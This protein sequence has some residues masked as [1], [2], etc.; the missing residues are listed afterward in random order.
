MAAFTA[1]NGGSP[2]KTS[3][4]SNPSIP[5][6][7][8]MRNPSDERSNGQPPHP[9]SKTNAE[10][11]ANQRE[12]W[13]G[14]NQDRSPYQSANY[15]D[16]DGSLKR[17]RSL[18]P[19][20]EHAPTRERTPDQ[21]SQPR[22][23][24]SRE[25]YRSPPRE[26][27]QYADRDDRDGDSWYSREDRE[28][29]AYYE[30]TAQG[31]TEEQIGEALRRANQM[32]SQGDYDNNSPDGDDR[33]MPYSPYT[34][35]GG[36][37]DPSLHSDPK[38]R[39]RN[40][41]NRTK[42]GCMTCRRRK[43]KCD[44]QKPECSNCI[45]GGFVCA[46][47]PPQ[48]N[49]A[50]QKPDNKVAAIPL[51]SKDPS[52]VPP[53][54]YGMPQQT[55]YGNQP[56]VGQP[57]QAQPPPQPQ[58]QQQQQQQP[59]PPPPPQQQVPPPPPPPPPPQPQ[60][61]REPLPPYRGQ[62]LRIDTPQGRPIL[63]EDDRP[64]ATALSAT[65]MSAL[66]GSTLTP[67]TIPS[68]TSA[69]PDKLAAYAG[70]FSQPITQPHQP[71]GE[72]KEYQRIPPLH[73]VSRTA[74]DPDTPHPAP[75]LP[76]ITIHHPTRSNSPSSQPPVTSN[77]QVAAQLALSHTFA[78]SRPRSQKE[79][80]LSGRHYYPFDK[81]LVLER[82][83]CS[84]A[85]W[86]FNNSTNPN[87][88]VS[89]NER[90]RLFREILQPRDASQISPTNNSPGTPYGRVGE[91]VVVEAPFVCDYGYNIS[92]GQNVIVGRN[93]TVIDTC[94]VKIGDNCHIGPNVSLYTATLPIDPKRRMGSKGPQLG[95]PITIEPD[96][97]IGGNV[98]ILPGVT[99]GQGTTIG[100]GSVVTKNMP[101]FTIAIGN[102]ANIIRGLAGS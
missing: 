2:T 61:R 25:P 99:I 42:T 86:R 43:K 101:P 82:E 59:P 40:F 21:A 92:I 50:W 67:S 7:D 90:A 78:G 41:S 55:P 13:A 5:S 15:P 70:S 83:R 79:E 94:E 23:P 8:H 75:P 38:K 18:S 56:A 45:R 16:V 71:Y 98:V 44:E 85:C 100:A 53:G 96:C 95:K 35:T 84:A 30:Q 33:G 81:E 91:N 34:P 51:E 20:R 87:N 68:A 80:M 57:P 72:R 77:V 37:R 28:E 62:P 27:R 66:S 49:A 24:E 65:A 89:P 69:N 93:C 17:K 19:R 64:T 10:P 47:Y 88:G 9:D 54:A 97:W 46:G 22:P 4:P 6:A 58:T 39:K 29:R 73:D 60:Q 31:Q 76:H 102:P 11:S 1:L 52:Y 48:R 32:D 12:S 63:T 14:P 26:Q 3:E 74:A 36:P